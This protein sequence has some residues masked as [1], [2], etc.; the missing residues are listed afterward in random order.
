MLTADEIARW[1]AKHARHAQPL[2]KP[3]YEAFLATVRVGADLLDALRG[4]WEWQRTVQDL[5]PDDLREKVWGL[6][7][8][9]TVVDGP[10]PWPAAKTDEGLRAQLGAALEALGEVQSILYGADNATDQDAKTRCIRR[11]FGVAYAARM[12]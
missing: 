7:G 6:L 4:M 1:A 9:E 11:A 3:Y 8:T 10:L 12:K 5:V 2:E